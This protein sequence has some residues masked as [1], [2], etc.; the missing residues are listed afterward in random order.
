MAGIVRSLI[1][2]I[3][4]RTDETGLKKVETRTRQVKREMRAASRAAFT[5]RRDLRSLAF[6]VKSFAAAVI[7]GRIAQTFT[8]D[9]AKAA[10]EAA[11]FSKSI[12]IT[13]EAYQ[14][15]TFAAKLNGA[16]QE[17]INKALPQLAKRA[18][19][20]A[21]GMKKQARGFR[22]LGVSV[23]DASGNLKSADRLFLEVADGMVNLKD[24]GRRT[25][26]AMDLFGR[27][28]ATLMPTF[29]QGAKGIKKAML[30]AK[31]LGIVMTATQ[32]K[33]AEDFNDELLRTKAVLKGVRNQ[34]AVRLLPA[35]TKNLKAF[36]EW[37]KEGDNLEKT[38]NRIIIAAKGLAVALSLVVAVKI[39]QSLATLVAVTKKA[40][41]WTRLQ[42]K[43]TLIAWAPYIA[44]AAAIAAV[45]LVI[46]SLI[47]WSRG[48]KSAVGDL[49]EHFGLA[50]KARKIVE[51]LKG[52]WVAFVAFLP[53]VGRHL[54][55]VLGAMDKLLTALWNEF[56]ADL[57]DLGKA[58]VA[59]FREVY[60]VM[61]AAATTAHQA[62]I[63]LV[64]ALGKAWRDDIK[65]AVLEVGAALAELWVA[66]KPA[67]TQM[68]AV[69][70]E[71]GAVIFAIAKEAIP[72]FGKTLALVF[73][74]IAEVIRFTIR[75]ATAL[76]QTVT[77]IVSG[78]KS[79]VNFMLRLV[80][81]QGKT[82]VGAALGSA[83]VRPQ[84]AAAVPTGPTTNTLSVGTVSVSVTGTANMTPEELQAAV[85]IG[86]KKVFQEEIN[87]AVASV[88]SLVPA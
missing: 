67:L 23:K 18:A 64:H 4:F 11:K 49:I 56:G 5:L 58:M 70:K 12:G 26:I 52:A 57:T 83:G 43:A 31:K 77:A 33:I 38:L 55:R 14:G 53:A 61:V 30:E 79:A 37:A 71:I 32:A 28:G 19:E 29:L 44:L 20:A 9:F 24:K 68:W 21:D 6:G 84:P 36:Q 62:I 3:L 45:V 7:T 2:K 51:A 42:G 59:L 48:G 81:L 35:I 76:V 41:F 74:A 25:Q 46:Q 50:D 66:A 87:N 15:L 17:N 85:E 80:G 63:E 82:T 65:P 40:V 10:D 86:T 72:A 1:T 8:V 54:L 75:Q 69:T 13:M 27:T 16:T 60:P 47:V 22:R 34:I 78:I 73:R 39:G 88:R